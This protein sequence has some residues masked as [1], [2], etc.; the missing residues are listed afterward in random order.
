MTFGQSEQ[1][2]REQKR[3]DTPFAA[4]QISKR[5]ED[6]AADDEH[7]LG[8]RSFPIENHSGRQVQP[9]RQRPQLHPLAWREQRGQIDDARIAWDGA[10][11]RPVICG[12]GRY[13]DRNSYGALPIIPRTSIIGS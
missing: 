6:P 12:V 8:D 9:A 13:H 7:A 3:N 4:W 1:V 10:Q 5:F 11:R 2:V